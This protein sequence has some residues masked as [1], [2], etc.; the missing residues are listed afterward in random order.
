MAHTHRSEG[1]VGPLAAWRFTGTL[2]HYQA[3]AL[4]RVGDAGPLH[5]VAPPGSGKTLLGLLLAARRGGRAVVL[6]PTTTI[7]GQWAATAASLAPAGAEAVS[8]DSATPSDLTALTY[9][10]LSV[11]DEANPLE[12]LARQRWVADLEASGRSADAAAAWLDDLQATNERAYTSGVSRRS[13]SLR[14]RLAR[15]DP[16]VLESALHP[17]ARALVDRLVA[18]GVETVVLDECHHLLDHWAMVVAL[19]VARLREA[20]RSPLVIGL[21]A[22]LPSP[23]DAE[24]YDNYTSLLGDVDYEVPTPAVVREGNLAPYRDLVRFVEPVDSELAFL[25]SR[26]EGLQVLI[27]LTFARDAG[28]AHVI[29]TLQPPLPEPDAPST[30][31]LQPSP[32]PPPPLDAAALVDAR[33]AL[34][35]AAD[36]VGA[37]AAAAML[38]TVAPQ[39]EVVAALPAASRRPP[40][41]DEAMRLLSR[42]ALERVLPDPEQRGQWER[43][44]RSLADFGYALTDRGVRRSRDPVDTMLAS[45]IAKDHGACDILR[46]ERASLGDARL[47]ALVVTDFARHGNRQGGLVTAA[48]AL[49]TFDVIATDVATRDLAAVL[50]TGSTT[51]V[52]TAC[53]EPV[54]AALVGELGIPVAATAL[55]DRPAVSTLHAPG[56]TTSAIVRAVSALLT[57]GVVSVVVGTRGLFGEGWDCPAVNTLIDLTA[58]STASATQQ[59]RGRTLRLDPAWPAKVAHNWTVTGLLPPGFPVEADPD[60]AR[61]RRKHARLWGLDRDDRSRVTRGLGIAL[62]ATSRAE[63]ARATGAERAS[64]AAADVSAASLNAQL[65]ADLLPRETTHA[66]WRVGEPYRDDERVSAVLLRPARAALFRTSRPVARTLTGA[67]TLLGAATVGGAAVALAVPDL[68]AVVGGAALAV[69]A[70]AGAITLAPQAIRARRQTERQER[71]Y[72]DAAGVVWEALRAAGRVADIERPEML[73]SRASVTAGSVEWSVTCPSAPVADQRRLAEALTEL[74]GPVR[75]PRFLLQVGTGRSSWFRDAVLRVGR[76]REEE[77]LPV[78]ARIG[79]R[80]EDAA[81]FAAHWVR[82]IGPCTLHELDR[83]EALALAVRARRSAGGA[84][85]PA[86]RDEWL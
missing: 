80:R 26:A 69:A 51:R 62:S 34:A 64:G 28:L 48:G 18:H 27:R 58:V 42:F 53:A 33:L 50:V 2:R 8:E 31:P 13:R 66:D 67:S 24:E 47:R 5:I 54:V 59:L 49:R 30:D 10:A 77:F 17:N 23:D 52:S 41:T 86:A 9:Q 16:S 14:R 21:T 38:A 25:R 20:G 1:A 71:G 68:A 3:D 63:L 19:L 44:R 6:A 65:E 57:R 76:V 82:T 15:E 75:T 12:R 81:A 74:F 83:P 35:F 29:D 43:I 22:T 45:S 73:V 39:H 70:G 79:R 60:A 32:P 56:A 55:P 72:Q 84:P 46:L 36:F 85:A 11:L 4:A 40:T 37:E 7:R 61:L 78:P